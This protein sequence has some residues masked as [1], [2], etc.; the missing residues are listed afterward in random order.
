MLYCIHLV[1]IFDVN[2]V[3]SFLVRPQ[4]NKV[5]YSCFVTFKSVSRLRH[6]KR[7]VFNAYNKL[8][9]WDKGSS[10]VSGNFVCVGSFPSV[11]FKLYSNAFIRVSY[12]SKHN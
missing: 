9:K 8:Q 4:S 3:N 5:Q 2:V 6:P 12:I 11:R 10:I 7:P 1:L